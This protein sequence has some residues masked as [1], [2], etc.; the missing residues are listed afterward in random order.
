MDNGFSILMFIFAAALLLYAVVLVITKDYKMLPYRAQISVKP[1]DP[2]EYTL[3]LAKVVTLVGL[4]VAVG[5][6]VAL[7]NLLIGAIV[8]LTGVIAAIWAGTRIVK[9][10]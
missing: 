10:R 4:A 2:K 7:W 3:Q 1:K 8:V 5:A 6:V 9:D